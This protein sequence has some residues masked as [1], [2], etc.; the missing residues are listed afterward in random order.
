MSDND[1]LKNDSLKWSAPMI[2]TRLLVATHTIRELLEQINKIE[3]STTMPDK[4]KLL[5]IK[6]IKQAIVKVR[7]EIDII[8][9]E[10]RLSNLYRVS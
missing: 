4:D 7:E 9:K 5:E 10:I 2:A 1:N 3:G 6:K 8:K